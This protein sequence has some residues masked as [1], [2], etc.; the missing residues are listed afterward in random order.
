MGASA[1]KG[2]LCAPYKCLP[3]DMMDL[4]ALLLAEDADR[5]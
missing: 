1:L 2:A 3:A 4:L 5:G